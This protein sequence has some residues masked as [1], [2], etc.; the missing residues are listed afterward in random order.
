[1]LN[2][3]RLSKSDLEDTVD[4][5]Y[6]INVSEPIKDLSNNFVTY[7][8]A[9]NILDDTDCF[10]I[11]FNNLWNPFNWFEA[12][13]SCDSHHIIKP[14]AYGITQLSHSNVEAIVVVVPYYDHKRTLENLISTEL[15]SM[16][17]IEN[18]LLKPF[19]D[20]LKFCHHKGLSCGN[21]NLSNILI[22]GTNFVLR[23]PFI[24]PA[25]YYQDILYVPTELERC[26]KAGMNT[27]DSS[28]D[29]FAL[30]V[31]MFLAHHGTQIDVQYYHANKLKYGVLQTLLNIYKQSLKEDYSF[32]RVLAAALSPNIEQRFALLSWDVEKPFFSRDS[33]GQNKDSTLVFNGE[34]YGFIEYLSAAMI[35]YWDAANTFVN[36]DIFLK[37]LKNYHISNNIYD[38]VH[39]IITNDK[40]S[41][42]FNS[43]VDQHKLTKILQ[44]LSYSPIIYMKNLSVCIQSLPVFAILALA[45]QKEFELMKL[46]TIIKDRLYTYFSESTLSRADTFLELISDLEYKSGTAFFGF[47]RFVYWTNPNLPCLSKLTDHKHVTTLDEILVTLEDFAS[48]SAERIFWDAHLI[49][50]LACKLDVHNVDSLFAAAYQDLSFTKEHTFYVLLM[51]AKAQKL[52]PHI[53]ILNLSKYL[54]EQIS[55]LVTDDV[56]NANLRKVIVGQIIRAGEEQN[57]TYI[58][59]LINNQKIYQNDKNGYSKARVE[60]ARLTAQISDIED[61]NEANS[62]FWAQKIT[63]I[64]S[65]VLCLVISIGLII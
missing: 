58:V 1:M 18:N 21:I 27:A 20:L 47:E 24:S 5:R 3:F 17:M 63:V 32:N 7:Y 46:D 35:E 19:V 59:E 34:R 61:T 2:K 64:V 54:A 22:I 49:A 51:V 31:L 4:G 36:D 56:H 60:V 41:K 65:Y 10:A 55:V 40:T 43:F 28:A 62:L 57:L 23:E 30:G 15:L 6:R 11:A 37:S 42:K 29:L 12:L 48:T 9:K 16:N 25:N 14:L 45:H 39:S 26:H 52:C 33:Y 53:G 13:D 50:F 44:T 8:Q 38:A